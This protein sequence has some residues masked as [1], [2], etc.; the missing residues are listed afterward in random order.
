MMEKIV[1]TC[2]AK[3]WKRPMDMKDMLLF[4][5]YYEDGVFR[6]DRMF[7][8]EK[9]TADFLSRFDKVE[10]NFVDKRKK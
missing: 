10:L 2:D 6:T 3:L 9:S 5:E 8:I 7:P 1:L 4:G